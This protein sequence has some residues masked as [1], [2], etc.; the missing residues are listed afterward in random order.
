MFHRLAASRAAK[1]TGMVS[2]FGGATSFPI[3]V[4]TATP[5][6]SGPENSETAAIPRAARGVMAR[7]A[8]MVATTLALSWKPFRKSKVSARMRRTASKM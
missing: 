1:T 7:E 2:A 3:V 4:A 6:R 8:I 5:K